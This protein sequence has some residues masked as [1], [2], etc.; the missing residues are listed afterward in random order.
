M[1]ESM[2][3]LREI[4]EKC[5]QRKEPQ[6]SVERESAGGQKKKI[7]KT[8]KLTAPVRENAANHDIFSTKTC[9]YHDKKKKKQN[10]RSS[11][12]NIVAE[13]ISNTQLL[14]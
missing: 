14:A 9:T 8:T 6:K 11:N 4:G 12:I 13:G 2:N 5:E 10:Q 7:I 3:G 1:T